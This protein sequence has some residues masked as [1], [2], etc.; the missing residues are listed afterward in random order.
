MPYDEFDVL[1]NDIDEHEL[2]LVIY[3]ALLL[4]LILF[5]FRLEELTKFRI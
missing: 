2:E 5:D 3:S 4:I 1:V